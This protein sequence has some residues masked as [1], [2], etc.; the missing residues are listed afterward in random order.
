MHKNLVPRLGKE[1]RR[2]RLCSRREDAII[3]VFSVASPQ[4]LVFKRVVC[5]IMSHQ[6]FFEIMREVEVAAAAALAS[7]HPPPRVCKP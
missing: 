7:Q 2:S 1:G 6:V 4:D 5:L 3:T